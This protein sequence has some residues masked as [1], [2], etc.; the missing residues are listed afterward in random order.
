MERKQE[1]QLRGYSENLGVTE[2]HH[3]ARNSGIIQRCASKY[4]TVDS[5][6]GKA[7]IQQFAT[8]CGVNTFTM[9]EFKLPM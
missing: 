6:R 1:E 7:L 3:S 4:L 5:P 2:L 9:A 8:F